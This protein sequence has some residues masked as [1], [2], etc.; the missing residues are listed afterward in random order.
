MITD[1]IL[2]TSSVPLKPLLSVPLHTGYCCT[3]ENLGHPSDQVADPQVVSHDPRRIKF[4]V[5][6]ACLPP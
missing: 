4:M 2:S 6:K 3:E 1:P 5:F